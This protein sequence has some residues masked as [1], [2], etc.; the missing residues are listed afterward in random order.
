MAI[1]ANRALQ[2]T[3]AILKFQGILAAKY[4][5]NGATVTV[6]SQLNYLASASARKMCK[7]DTVTNAKTALSICQT[8]SGTKYKGLSKHVSLFSIICIIKLQWYSQQSVVLTL[9]QQLKFS[10]S[11]NQTPQPQNVLC[12]LITV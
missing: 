1:T 8:T 5:L 9:F 10:S 2:D 4:Q 11:K 7:E 3:K 6:L 12:T